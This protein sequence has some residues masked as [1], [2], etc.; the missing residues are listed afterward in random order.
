VEAIQRRG[1][2][3]LALAL[4]GRQDEIVVDRVLAARRFPNTAG[5]GLRESGVEMASGAVIV[6][7][8]MQTSVAHIYAAGNASTTSTKG[9]ISA[10]SHKATAEGIVAAESAMGLT[11]RMDDGRLPRCLFTWPE[12]AWV[13]LSE[14]QAVAQVLEVAVG[15]APMAINPQAIMLG[16]TAGVVKVVADRKYGKI[17]G[18]HIMAPGA[19]ELINTAAVAMLSEATV[20]ELMHLVPAHPSIGEALVDAAMDVEKRSLHLP[21]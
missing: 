12:V 18:V 5:L 19:A 4:A 8:H 10:W 6:D 17:L 1:A 11:S 20:R 3:S 16:E 13:G 9:D 15:R 21:R 7:D 14:E 2:D